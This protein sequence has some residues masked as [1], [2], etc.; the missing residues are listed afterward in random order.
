MSVTS[1][2]KSSVTVWI[3][4]RFIDRP[5]TGVERVALGLI[6]AIAS[7]YLDSKGRWMDGGNSYQFRLV[8]PRGGRAA[9]PWP[10][11]PLI[12]R[13]YLRGHAWEQFDLPR[14][15]AGDWLLNLCNTGPMF[16]R[17]QLIYL[18]DAQPFA[19]PENFSARFR[20]WYRIL[21]NIAGRLSSAVLVNSKFTRQE[22]VRYVGLDSH[23]IKL[24]YAGSE[25]ARRRTS[26]F[27]CLERFLLPKT[28][29]LLAV[30]SASPNKNF[31]RVL[32]AVELLGDA[33]PPC[34]IVGRN[35]QRHFVNVNLDH[36]NI[37]RLGYVSDDELFALYE[38]A[39]C[40]VFPSHYE[41]FGL[42]PL[43]AMA[44]GC[45]VVVSDTT[46]MRE[47][48]GPEGNYCDPMSSASIAAA[49]ERLSSD[50]QYRER[51]FE[52]GRIRAKEFSWTSSGRVL[53][54]TLSHEA[55]KST[56]LLS[57]DH[58]EAQ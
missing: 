50:R 17:R 11:I 19:I 52:V 46:A 14:I 28:Q 15:T 47:V 48:A 33:A 8:A 26:D 9:S 39:L 57:T 49:I 24:C 4:A 31:Q 38:K 23:K 20:I 34:V 5:T 7:E 27:R 32:E 55:Q 44:L 37:I 29:F 43:E 2:D 36:D 18:H 51:M 41:G 13:G 30:S 6:G 10:N 56:V 35:D 1:R 54:K 22:L 53:L 45:P 42:P 58:L 12:R 25:H 21:F 3:N 16:K 40:L